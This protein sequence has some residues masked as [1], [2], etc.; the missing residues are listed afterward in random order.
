MSCM[1]KKWKPKFYIHRHP[2]DPPFRRR[3]IKESLTFRR[4]KKKK[5]LTKK[6]YQKDLVKYIVQIIA[7][8]FLLGIVFVAIYKS[9]F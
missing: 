4:L 6:K 9:V 7:C 1:K 5:S 8:V 2:D 3:K